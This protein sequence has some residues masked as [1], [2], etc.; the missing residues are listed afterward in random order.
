MGFFRA[1]LLILAAVTISA[2]SCLPTGE[3]TGLLTDKAAK[4]ETVSSSK[5]SK[6]GDPISQ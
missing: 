5:T 3:T 6:V 1:L 2:C 4:S